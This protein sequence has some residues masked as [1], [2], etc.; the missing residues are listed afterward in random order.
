MLIYVSCESP[1]QLTDYL[2]LKTGPCFCM[3]QFYSR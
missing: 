3:V 1:E 2:H